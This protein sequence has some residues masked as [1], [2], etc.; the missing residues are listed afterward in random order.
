MEKD[1]EKIE[2]DGGKMEEDEGGGKME[3]G[4]VKMEEDGV[5]ME[6]DGGGG[7]RMVGKHFSLSWLQ[8]LLVLVGFVGHGHTMFCYC[9]GMVKLFGVWSI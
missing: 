9:C 2:E 1:G 4:G 8:P 5:K 6:E 3:E 7:R